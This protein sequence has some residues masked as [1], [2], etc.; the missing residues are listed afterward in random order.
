MS[1]GYYCE[2][3]G[4]GNLSGPC[5][6]GYFCSVTNLTEVRPSGAVSGSG[7]CPQGHWCARGTVSLCP[8]PFDRDA[9][10]SIWCLVKVFICIYHGLLLQ[11]FPTKCPVGTFSPTS[12]NTNQSACLPCTAGWYCPVEGMYAIDDFKCAAGYFCP[13]GE[14]SRVQ[15]FPR[16][17]SLIMDHVYSLHSL[18]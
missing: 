11:V 9:R 5:D 6:P 14:L 7:P 16:T 1:Q 2:L 18:F 13:A 12:T 4:L 10:C 8:I 15:L 3:E 17:T